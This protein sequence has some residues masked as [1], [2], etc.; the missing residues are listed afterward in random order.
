MKRTIQEYKIIEI[1]EK[2]IE[3]KP[4]EGGLQI[5]LNGSRDA[6]RSERY[7]NLYS[8]HMLF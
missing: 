4:S 3:V 6:Q 5:N 7:M 8:A 2:V 1:A